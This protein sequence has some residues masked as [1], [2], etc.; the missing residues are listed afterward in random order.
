MFVFP[1]QTHHGKRRTGAVYLQ[2]Q[3]SAVKLKT[4]KLAFRMKFASVVGG[5]QILCHFTGIAS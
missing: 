1:K 2:L 5:W 4:E 3:S